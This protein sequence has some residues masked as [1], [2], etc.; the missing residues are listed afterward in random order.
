MALGSIFHHISFRSTI[1][2]SFTFRS[3]NQKYQI[4]LLYR[5]SISNSLTL[6]ITMKVLTTPFIA[7]GASWCLFVQVFSDLCVVSY[8]IDTLV[9][10]T[11]GNTYS[12]LLHHPFLFKGKTNTSSRSSINRSLKATLAD[13]AYPTRKKLI[14]FACKSF[15]GTVSAPREQILEPVSLPRWST[16]GIKIFL[17]QVLT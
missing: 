12:T 15:Y 11:E 5:L 1:L 3:L 14:H 16:Y 9:F 4:Y 10:K 7:L 8:W 6:Q 13:Q 2:Q 17:R